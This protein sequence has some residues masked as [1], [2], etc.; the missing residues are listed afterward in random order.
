MQFAERLRPRR[1]EKIA[2]AFPLPC[3]LV[4]ISTCSLGGGKLPHQEHRR[5]AERPLQVRIADLPASRAAP[6][7]GRLMRAGDKSGV[8]KKIPRP[9]KAADVVNFVQQ[10]QCQNLADAGDAPQQVVA[11]WIVDFGRAGKVQLQPAELLVEVVDQCQ[12]GLDVQPA[13]G[14]G[15]NS[16]TPSRLAA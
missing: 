5:L 1:D 4:S 15:N 6:L 11:V 16:A 12:V 10:H 14:S 13:L 3:L 2:S 8:G 9:R 7:A